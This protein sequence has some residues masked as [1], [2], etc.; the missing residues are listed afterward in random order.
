MKKLW[1]CRLA[2]V[3][4]VI[5]SSLLAT[6]PVMAIWDWCAFDPQLS[7]N[8]A[9]LDIKVMVGIDHG[10]PNKLFNGDM[11]LTVT[12]P[13]GTDTGVISCDK[14]IKIVFIE[15]TGLTASEAGTPVGIDLQ[16]RAKDSDPLKVI[17]SLNGAQLEE[18]VGLTD[19]PISYSLVIP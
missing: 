15:T 10:S 17:V 5:V 4:G 8:G 7:I 3:V 16:L 9:T 19:E 13:V 14:K 18:I 2:V 1:F 11:L 6:V 12:V